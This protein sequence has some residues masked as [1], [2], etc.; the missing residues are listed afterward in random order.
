[1]CFESTLKK[2]KL[3]ASCLCARNDVMLNNNKNSTTEMATAY[4]GTIISLLSF[5]ARLR[6]VTPKLGPETHT[7]SRVPHFPKLFSPWNITSSLGRTTI[8]NIMNRD[9]GLTRW[10]DGWVGGYISPIRFVSVVGCATLP[11]LVKFTFI[12]NF[13]IS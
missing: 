5:S 9:L 2:N 13:R 3:T 1:M 4:N 6:K 12:L 7:R 10:M 11:K 8:M